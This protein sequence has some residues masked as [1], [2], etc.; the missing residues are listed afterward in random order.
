MV[1]QKSRSHRPAVTD[2]CYPWQPGAWARLPRLGLLALSGAL[3][4][5]Y[6]AAAVLKLCDG[7]S[8]D[9]WPIQ[10]PVYLAFLSAFTNAFL[11]FAF[12]EGV[13]ISWWTKALRTSSI[14]NLHRNWGYGN[15]LWSILTSRRPFSLIRL[16]GFI[17]TFVVIDGPLLQRAS[18][19]V[20]SA[21]ESFMS[22]MVP[23]SPG[24]FVT[25]ATGILA[26]TG[27]NPNFFTPTFR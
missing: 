11:R 19:P 9:D 16:A 8:I 6:G 14:R 18:V 25:G 21:R 7:Q 26:Y 2:H 3:L 10:P 27:R 4:C 5:A 20:A 17:V 1:S 24:P 12:A 23:I 15:S 13:T 22:L